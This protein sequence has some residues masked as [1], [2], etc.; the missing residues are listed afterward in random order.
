MAQ[1]TFSQVN[2]AQAAAE[3][4]QLHDNFF[5]FVRTQDKA[6]NPSPTVEIDIMDYLPAVAV[7]LITAL[8]IA[9][10]CIPTSNRTLPNSTNITFRFATLSEKSLPPW[11]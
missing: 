7:A 5:D 4:Q 1:V 11:P 10:V 6:N 9:S 8:L 2:E 3:K